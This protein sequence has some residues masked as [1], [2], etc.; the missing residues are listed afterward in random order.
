MIA[1]VEHI[2]T[3]TVAFDGMAMEKEYVKLM[4]KRWPRHDFRLLRSDNFTSDKFWVTGQFASR[5][6]HESFMAE[7]WGDPAWNEFWK[8]AIKDAKAGSGLISWQ[9]RLACFDEV[10]VE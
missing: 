8:G 7:F 5:A 2:F 10:S 4:R 9:Y 1:V 3:S 6:E